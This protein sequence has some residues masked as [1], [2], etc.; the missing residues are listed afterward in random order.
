VV[1]TGPIP[2][3]A[4][5][6]TS[7]D[8]SVPPVSKAEQDRLKKHA[9]PSIRR[10]YSLYLA[11]DLGWRAAALLPDNDEKTA[12]LLNT[13]GNW[14]KGRDDGAADRFYQAIERRCPKTELGRKAIKRHWFVP[15]DEESGK[16]N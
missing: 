2:V 9:A 16:P 8:K 1:E 3:I 4:M 12:E 10:Y 6:Y 11:A 7:R 14:L 13:T 15:V 5:K